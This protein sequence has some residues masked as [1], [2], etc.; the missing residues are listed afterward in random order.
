[1][2]GAGFGRRQPPAAVLVI[3]AIV[4]AIS[5][6]ACNDTS[7]TFS[8]LQTPTANANA[9]AGDPGLLPGESPAVVA[10]PD[11]GEAW[12]TEPDPDRFLTLDDGTQVA[13][14]QYL[15]MLDPS[16][17]QA[18]AEEVASWIGGTI[19]G[20]IAYIGV[21]KVLAEVSSDSSGVEARLGILAAQ[22][23]VQA[24]APVALETV[25][26]EPDC[27]PGLSDKV[28]SGPNADP[29]NLIG[30]K[31]AWQALYASGLPMGA[32]HVGF[33]D[34][35]LTRDPKGPIPWE[36]GNVTFD[37]GAKTT[38][39]LGTYD[40]FNHSDGT[41]GVFAGDGQNGGIVGIDSPLGSRLIV[42]HDVLGGPAK[43]G[44]LSKWTA[45]EGTSYT[46]LNLMNTVREI[47]A[48][49]TIIN[50]SWASDKVGPEKAP[51][52]AMWK[53]FFAQMAKDHPNVLF[54]YAAGNNG[55]A[56]D[57]TNH[58][59]GGISS[60]NVI[61][62]GNV[63]NDGGRHSTSNSFQP[64]S[65]G[66]VTL[67][68]PGDKAV[69]GIGADGKLRA[70]GGGTSSATPMV[71]ATAA[72]IRSIDPKLSAAEIK[73]M[74]AESAEV[75]DY[76]VGGK[77]L[78]VDLAVREAI[79]G[80]RAKLQPPKPPLTDAEIAAATQY[81]SID[82]TNELKERLTPD[83]ASRWQVRGSLQA[84]PGPTVMT[85]IVKG[86]RNPDW[87]QA[88]T[89]PAA[90]ATWQVLVP[91]E[92]TWVVVTRLDNGFWLKRTLSDQ[93][94]ATPTPTA[95]PSPTVLP[96]PS[97]DCSHPIDP[98]NPDYLKWWMACATPRTQ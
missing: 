34:S 21:W 57:G 15:I 60:P 2:R 18:E 5:F 66:E 80:A 13:P 62:V 64:G 68:A 74:I 36:F 17:T 51:N 6:G 42:S 41:L 1:M 39:N 97:F 93:G 72:L 32:V 71:S 89:A 61:T 14:D 3:A 82:L 49:A 30:V 24:A 40:G 77:T 16:A 59:P 12:T 98:P 26:A 56:M 54:V 86:T 46:D 88:V 90:A 95:T 33:L 22:K 70:A 55:G 58:Y 65:D 23:G 67:G 31:A 8:P 78:R 27:A 63:D 92:G 73:T 11:L 50:G 4:S 19:G 37:G 25:Q 20:H 94:A 69:W 84:I 38:T 83:G 44:Q 53:K 96:G 76:E 81:C 45:K 48:G 7:R 35:P 29:Y 87:R 52:A 28:Y 79:D 85:L 75:G 43:P 47:E 9:S 91:K 10:G